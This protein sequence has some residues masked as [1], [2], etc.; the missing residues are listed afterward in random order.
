VRPRGGFNK[1]QMAV[2]RVVCIVS[3]CI[4]LDL[5]TRIIPTSF[6]NS[7]HCASVRL[8]I[9]VYIVDLLAIDGVCLFA[10]VLGSFWLDWRL[11]EREIDVERDAQT[12]RRSQLDSTQLTTLH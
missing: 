8:P 3:L 9:A 11:L 6:T 1:S 4:G 5:G 10:I 7:H 2:A 12:H